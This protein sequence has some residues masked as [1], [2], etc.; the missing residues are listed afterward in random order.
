MSR[1]QTLASTSWWSTVGK[2]RRR[3]R[4]PGTRAWGKR[5]RL[6]SIW[7]FPPTPAIREVIWRLSDQL[8]GLIGV[9]TWKGASLSPSS[10]ERVAPFRQ[11]WLSVRC[12]D[13]Q[14]DAPFTARSG[15]GRFAAGAPKSKSR[16]KNCCRKK[17]DDVKCKTDRKKT[18]DDNFLTCHSFDEV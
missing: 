12:Q 17:I 8:S 7:I 18:E 4:P 10:S 9:S 16:K 13:I 14:G 6:L 5:A 2:G 11:I 15:F 1:S 3:P